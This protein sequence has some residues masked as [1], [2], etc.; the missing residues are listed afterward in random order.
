MKD[1]FVN[2]N[3]INLFSRRARYIPI[4]LWGGNNE[5][6]NEKRLWVGAFV[7]NITDL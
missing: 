6:N 2:F 5:R 4:R 3:C 7:F 1:S